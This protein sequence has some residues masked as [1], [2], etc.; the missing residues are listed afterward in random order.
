[1][2]LTIII[3]LYTSRV[4]LNALGISDYGINNIV[5]GFIAMFG[6]LNSAMSTSIQRNISSRMGQGDTEGLKQIFSAALFIHA[7][8]AIITFLIAELVGVWVFKNY[9]NI[10]P[11]RM[12]AALWVYHFAALSFSCS[13]IRVPFTAVLNARENLITIAVF[14]FTRT[15]TR[16]GIALYLPFA[17]SDKLVLFSGLNFG[18][19]LCIAIIYSILVFKIY[20]EATIVP[21]PEKSLY[22][23]LSHFAGWSLL[24]SVANICRVQG[25][26]ILLN[27]FFG[28][29]LNAAYGIASQVQYQLENFSNMIITAGSPQIVKLYASG[30]VTDSQKLSFQLS[31]ACFGVQYILAIPFLL[32]VETI[33]RFWLGIV[34][35]Y[36]AAILK[37][38]IIN[39]L[40]R[41]IGASLY[42]YVWATGKIKA[43]TVATSAIHILNIPL[44][45]L[46]LKTGFPP[47]SVIGGSIAL[48]VINAIVVQIL[49]AKRI[50]FPAYNFVISVYARLTLLVI[51]SYGSMSYLVNLPQN[52][53]VSIVTGILIAP[54]VTAVLFYYMV[55]NELEKD[56][57]WQ[58]LKS[59]KH[60]LPI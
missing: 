20:P 36:T 10:G 41:A 53:G 48:S 44:A 40:I 27:L 42:T 22:K 23:T 1:M 45:Y 21:N 6:I 51:I 17:A 9:I 58:V 57:F 8:L 60:K 29:V 3:S 46:L 52:D 38:I 11:E 13:I 30:N 19:V 59:F 2:I 18:L 26:T 7:A 37:L 55:F 31:K 5:A 50:N 54:C 24:G 33:L 14:E 15:I 56:S 35:E 16:L 4:V 49:M 32:Q 12:S 25:L 43:Y 47:H 34:P 28:T 39:N